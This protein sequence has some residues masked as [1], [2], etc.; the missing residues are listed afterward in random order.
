MTVNVR[1]FAVT[2][3]LLGR[4]HLSVELASGSTVGALRSALQAAYP[5]IDAL[6]PGLL[7]AIGSQYATDDAPLSEGDDVALIPPVSGGGI[8]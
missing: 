5:A 2:R 1:L 7:I 4:P 6:V 3:Q 8:G